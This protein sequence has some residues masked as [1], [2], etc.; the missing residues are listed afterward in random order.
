[1]HE[2]DMVDDPGVVQQLGRERPVVGVLG[3][4]AENEVRCP[5]RQPL[6]N[7]GASSHN[8]PHGILPAALQSQPH[9]TSLECI[10]P[11]YTLDPAT[12]LS[13]KSVCNL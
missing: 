2:P 7:E 13:L 12:T 4:A 8:A 5:R 3:Q 1:M 10:D 9:N 6:R 11:I